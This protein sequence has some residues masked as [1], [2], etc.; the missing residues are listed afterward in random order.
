MLI[1]DVMPVYD[2]IKHHE[3]VLSARPEVVFDAIKGIDFGRSPYIRA[4][5]TLREL[6]QLVRGALPSER[7]DFEFLMNRGFVVLAEDP[8]REIVLGVAGRFWR[9]D[10]GMV[11][12]DPSEFLTL[13]LPNLAKATMNFA[14]TDLGGGKTKLTTETRVLCTD[15][16][17]RRNFGIYWKVIGPFSGFIR[18]QTLKLIADEV[19][20]VDPVKV[21][22]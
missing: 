15:N 14:V 22:L 1:D 5:L 10:G 11:R 3:A 20:R 21:L 12:V 6:P 7:L 9:P 19:G 13:E 4:L 8:D 16:K 18:T 17:A 2:V